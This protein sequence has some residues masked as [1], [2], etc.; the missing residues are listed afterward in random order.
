MHHQIDEK[1]CERQFVEIDEIDLGIFYLYRPLK[2]RIQQLH[3]A[4]AVHGYD[5]SPQKLYL[6]ASLRY[7]PA[8]LPLPDKSPLWQN[9]VQENYRTLGNYYEVHVEV[10]LKLG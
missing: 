6:D 7:M 8:T 2:I 5:D 1:L 10:F 4:Q 3:I 9:F